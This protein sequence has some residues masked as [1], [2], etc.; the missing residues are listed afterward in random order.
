L[1]RAGKLGDR[2]Q[3]PPP[4]P[5]S[6]DA[7]LLQVLRRQGRQNLAVDLIVAKGSLVLPEAEA[8]QPSR[9]I[10][11]R[12]PEGRGAMMIR[13]NWLVQD[14]TLVLSVAFGSI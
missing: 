13:P 10:H 6:R 8:L 5:K 9:D 11:A 4:M 12:S 7:Q 14:R 2:G 1:E 3:Q